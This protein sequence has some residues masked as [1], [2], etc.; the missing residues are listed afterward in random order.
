MEYRLVLGSLANA[1]PGLAVWIVALV[2]SSILMKR[3]SD[4]PE[5][6]LIL[7]SSLMLV[8]TFLS[9]PKPAIAAYLTQSGL[10]NVRAAGVISYI[11]LFLGLISLA[12]VV[13]LFYAIWKKFS[14]KI[15]ND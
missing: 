12:G 5:R 9:I 8:S 2:I 10:S 15:A 6:L 14:E 1:A 3:R 7:G 11:S 4:K 13:C